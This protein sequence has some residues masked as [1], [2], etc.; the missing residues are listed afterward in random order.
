MEKIVS[1]FNGAHLHSVIRVADLVVFRTPTGRQVRRNDYSA[2][3]R[4]LQVAQVGAVT[5]VDFPAHCHIKKPSS[6]HATE[7]AWV[8]IRGHVSVAYFDTDGAYLATRVLE[9]GD[10]SITYAGGHAY[11]MLGDSLIYE[12]KTG[13]YYGVEKDKVML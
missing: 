12:F 11:S 13:P 3:G 2:E 9:P 10:C 6:D 1:K 4:H 5:N 7:E 8:V